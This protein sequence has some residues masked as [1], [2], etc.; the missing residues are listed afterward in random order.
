MAAAALR[1]LCLVTAVCVAEGLNI[2]VGRGD[3]TGAPVE[4]TFMGYAKDGQVGEGIHTRQHARAFIAHDE[5]TDKRFAFVSVDAGMGSEVVKRLVVKKLADIGFGDLYF[6]DNVAVSGTHTHSCP[7]GYLA[8]VLYQISV[9]GYDAETTENYVD[10]V[11]D[12]IMAAHKDL[13]PRTVK[14]NRGAMVK[15]IASKNRSPTAYLL[16]PEEERARYPHGDTDLN[17]TQLN[18]FN[19]DG[20]PDG[21]FNWFATHGTSINNTNKLI[22]G[23]NKGWASQIVE[24]KYNTAGGLPGSSAFLAA[25]AATNLGDVSPN[26]QGA[27]CQD[28]GAPCDRIKSTCNGKAHMCYAL[29]P[30][31]DMFESAEIIANHQVDLALKLLE[32]GGD[33][34]TGPVDFRHTYVDFSKL[35]YNGPQGAVKLCPPAMGFSFAA[36]TTDGTG[37]LNFEQGT[38]ST[39]SANPFWRLV[40]GLLSKPT[41]E[42][43]DCHAPKQILLNTGFMDVPYPWDPVVMPIQLLRIGKFFILSVPSEFTTMA[44]RRLRNAVQKTL[45][46][47]GVLSSI[48]DGVFVIAGLSNGYASYTTTFE[49]YQAQR[50]EGGSTIFGPNEANG[51][52]QEMSRI[53]RDMARGVPSQTAPAPAGHDSKHISFIPPVLFDAQ[54]HEHHFGAALTTPNKSYAA[55]KETVSVHFQCANPRNKVRRASQGGHPGTYLHVEMAGAD[56]TWTPVANDDSVATKFIW[57]RHSKVAAQSFCEVKWQVPALTAAGTYRIAIFG[58]HKNAIG[59]KTD[60][61]GVSAPFGVVASAAP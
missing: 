29:G 41:K 43:M 37:P 47:E 33:A 23:D 7:G 8:A 50:Y 20:K 58:T 55:G 57:S 19:D 52:N 1:A 28:T 17:M 42:Q 14:W 51:F 3:A 31:R 16:N 45:V 11:V 35:V 2:G 10:G 49:E 54:S 4:V 21:I 30:G 12:A 53:A 15:D 18:F 5:I 44:G 39:H 34:L 25:F 59:H 32:Q 6:D 36:G 13:K 60:F 61:S 9:M 38:N 26:T 48:D 24:Q 40:G 46:E 56:G 27:R 22:S